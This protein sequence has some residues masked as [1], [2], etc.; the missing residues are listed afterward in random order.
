MRV[1]IGYDA[2]RF[3]DGRR[4]VLGGGAIPAP[5]GRAGHS[6]AH[7]LTHAHGA[8]DQGAETK[9][10]I[11]RTTAAVGLAADLGFR[12]ESVSVD[13]RGPLFDDA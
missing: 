4:L 2:H 9:H 5:R 10:M 7:V 11:L 13:Y 6:E 3:A 12:P 1:G 8:G